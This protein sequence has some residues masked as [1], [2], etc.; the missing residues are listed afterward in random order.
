MDSTTLLIYIVCSIVTILVVRF[1]FSIPAIIKNLKIQ[2]ALLTQI[3]IK[4]GVKEDVIRDIYYN[5]DKSI[6]SINKKI[7]IK[8]KSVTNDNDKLTKEALSYPKE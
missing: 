2:T 4:N 7:K 8:R 1:V 6:D 3:A 5:S